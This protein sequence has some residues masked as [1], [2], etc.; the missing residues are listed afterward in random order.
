MTFGRRRKSGQTSVTHDLKGKTV[1]VPF[2]HIPGC[3]QKGRLIPGSIK[4]KDRAHPGCMIITFQNDP[5]RFFFPAA[6]LRSWMGGH[7]SDKAAASTKPKD[8]SSSGDDSQDSSEDDE[9]DGGEDDLDLGGAAEALCF[10]AQQSRGQPSGKR[11]C[12]V[13]GSSHAATAT[14]AAAVAAAGG[15]SADISA[16]PPPA[17]ASDSASASARPDAGS[18]MPWLQNRASQLRLTP[19][20]QSP[21]P[22]PQLPEPHQ[23]GSPALFTDVP[24][25]PRSH[26]AAR[27]PPNP[28]QPGDSAPVQRPSGQE[29][30]GQ[31]P[32]GPAP[33]EAAAPAPVPATATAP[34]PAA[35]TV[36]VPATVPAAV[37]A[38]V[39][40]PA[41]APA[42]LRL[43]LHSSPTLH[44]DLATH[45]PRPSHTL[46]GSSK[47]QF[48]IP[49]AAAAAAA[50]PAAAA[51][52]AAVACA[53]GLPPPPPLLGQPP[54][55]AT[56][57][58]P[59]PTHPL[60][61]C[62]QP[63]RPWPSPPAAAGGWQR[64]S[65]TH[66]PAPAP[67]TAT[68]TATALL[69]WVRDV[70]AA[71]HRPAGDPAGPAP[72]PDASLACPSLGTCCRRHAAQH[73]AHPASA[74]GAS[75]SQPP[76]FASSFTAASAACTAD[77]DLRLSHAPMLPS[78]LAYTMASGSSQGAGSASFA[79]RGRTSSVPTVLAPG[80][81][82]RFHGQRTG[83]G[84]AVW[85]TTH[86]QASPQHGHGHGNGHGTR[87]AGG[88]VA[89]EGLT[90]NNQ[91]PVWPQNAPPPNSTSVPEQKRRRQDSPGG[92]GRNAGDG[93]PQCAAGGPGQGAGAAAGAAGAAQSKSRAKRGGKQA[94]EKRANKVEAKDLVGL[95][96]RMDGSG[97]RYWFPV[98]DL[99][100][101][102]V[103]KPPSSG[104]SASFSPEPQQAHPPPPPPPLPSGP[105]PPFTLQSGPSDADMKAAKAP[106]H[107]SESRRHSHDSIPQ[108]RERSAT[109]LQR[110]A[111]VVL[112]RQ[113]RLQPAPRA[114][115]RGCSRRLPPSAQPTAAA[116]RPACSSR[117][118][119]SG[120][121][122]G[123][124]AV[125][126]LR[127]VSLRGCESE[128]RVAG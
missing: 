74:T 83:F 33:D 107:R 77:P 81:P 112:L 72:A 100:A 92:V 52:A 40:A 98:H 68:A 128:G 116:H 13:A 62:S 59:Q 87:W 6:L 120:R 55:A 118:L 16:D 7:P 66:A 53:P 108:H 80:Q 47:H 60:G 122:R 124:P 97:I 3:H 73:G 37:P 90:Y 4:G 114:S 23:P 86:G 82:G 127:R 106:T 58:V 51:A 111:A 29:L 32:S 94:R 5:R 102:L 64:Q 50:A 91:R 43:S 15:T 27:S 85:S 123:R 10:L 99:R 125:P 67:A 65:L 14:A 45:P 24:R 44:L 69:G 103:P 117:G 28:T 21:F 26:A 71:A 9:T 119:L 113:G 42:P 11:S 46:G 34:F 35:A 48:P 18:R 105:A 56:A 38:T 1:L 39:P 2:E 31:E 36:P 110:T 79:E 76:S 70:S 93:A 30:T 115:A 96:V 95:V 121:D 63:G 61:H 75:M 126:H 89:A 25:R 101:W 19:P 20:P 88:G 104:A 84:N 54:V 49:A 8:N 41:P 57:A 12:T 22:H 109:P 78:M 17:H